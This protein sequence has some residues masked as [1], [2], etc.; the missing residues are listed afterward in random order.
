MSKHMP[1]EVRVPIEADNPAIMRDEAKCI[2]CG[3]CK[4]VCTDYIGVHGAYDL[5]CTGDRAVCINC[6]QC[7]NVCPVQCIT[8]KYEYPLVEEQIRDSGKIVIFSTSPSVRASLGEEFGMAQGSFVEG[9]MV[10]LLRALGADYVLDT[11]FSADLT[12]ME[13]AGELI[14]RI[15]NKKKPLPQFTSCCPAWVKYLETCLPEL[16]DNVSTA[17][18]PIGMQ[19]P[20]I[21][22]YFAKKR[23]LDPVRI[24]NVAVTPCTAKK[25]EIRRDEMKAAGDYYG[26]DGM[27]DMD[28]VITTREL[29]KWA[30]EKG[31]DFEALEESGF[32]SLMGTGSG[33]GVIFGN[34]GGVME[35][36]LRTAYEAITGETAPSQLFDLQPVRGMEGVREAE[37]AIGELSVRVAV[38]YGTA[39]AAAFIRKMKESGKEYHFVEVMTC[40]GGC[41]GGGGQP[42]DRQYQGDALRQKRID[43]LY[44]RDQAMA[45]RKS[46]E[47]PEIIKIYDEFL[48][49]PLS[50]LA[51]KML[52]TIYSDRSGDLG[53]A[54][55]RAGKGKTVCTAGKPY[56]KE[57]ENKELNNNTIHDNAL[58]ENSSDA[59]RPTIG[60]RSLKKFVCTV[61]GYIHE[62]DTP[63]AQCPVCKVGPDKFKE[64]IEEGAK[65]A[66]KYAGTR[67]EKNL[68]EAFAGESMARNKYRYFAELARR[69]GY[70]QIAGIFMETSDQEG[71]HAKMWFQESHGFGN[72]QEN[73]ETAA[74]GENDEWT[75]MYVRMAKEAREEGFTE[76]AEKFERVAAVEKT[77]EERYR[78]LI[79][80]L[81]KDLVFKDGE[82]TVWYCRQCGH[83]HVGPEAPQNCPTC[84]YP[85]AYFERRAENY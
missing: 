1:M 49:K 16:R 52:H 14:E 39:N 6:G 60:G 73:L 58:A 81:E 15:V 13:E 56:A 38:I 68:M 9:K 74:G 43:S 80:N 50:G 57:A 59:G 53:N 8:E 35:A 2:K 85:K 65:G 79:S 28:Y 7:A 29:A 41:I 19:G 21:K 25:F 67:T 3:Q 55:C 4:T 61:C 33:A 40:P 32:D 70:E 34:T 44:Q 45:L 12:I 82:N 84:G 11:N 78:K 20:M 18:S 62:G 46:H 31:I 51:E 54:A 69:E 76:L 24:V 26:T 37:L 27:R 63:P 71:Q 75:D 64:V 36:A 23:N 66:G 47:N 5:E 77:H 17:K 22:T 42:L 83:I 30:R 10:A 48:G 72:T